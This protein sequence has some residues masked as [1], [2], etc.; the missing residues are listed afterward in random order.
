MLPCG[1]DGSVR[2][3][4][5]SRRA[6]AVLWLVTMVVVTVMAGSSAG[7]RAASGKVTIVHYGYYW[8]GEAWRGFVDWAVKEFEETH[9]N[10]DIQVVVAGGPGQGA[11]DQKFLSMLAGGSPPD[12]LEM[13]ANQ[14]Q[15]F[16]DENVLLD[17]RLLMDKEKEISWDLFSPITVKMVTWT[18]GRIWGLPMDA[19]PL[20][21]AFNQNLFE[22]AGLQT[23]VDLGPKGWTWDTMLA[24][25]R[26]LTVDANGDGVV[27]RYGL[28]G[29]L[30]AWWGA[31]VHQAGGDLYDRPVNPTRATYNRPEVIRGLKF[32]Q[33]LYWK[34][35]VAVPATTGTSPTHT[36]WLGNVGMST[37]EGPGLI[38][39]PF[40][41]D[42]KFAWDI[43]PQ[44]R[45]P[46][47]GGCRFTVDA[48]EI[49]SGTRHPTEAWEWVKFLS[50]NKAV[51]RR[52]VA[53]TA[54][55]T[56]FQPIQNEYS[57]LVPYAPL[58]AAYMVFELANPDSGPAYLIPA[59]REVNAITGPL[60]Q[61]ILD[62]K[63]DPSVVA[64]EI[65]E[66]LNRLLAGGK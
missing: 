24:A 36:I 2:Y 21:V 55:L 62:G 43:G 11:Y 63:R 3:G 41:R 56:A 46:V 44:P 9:P 19:Y 34:Y 25:A 30:W 12:V 57:K 60:I 14:A 39:Q 17:L 40:I 38:S 6:A 59:A 52:F 16:V 10:I 33:D 29:R 8:H 45:G 15:S 23:P 65:D 18:D 35:K 64:V 51:V 37:V 32:V 20:F 54:R 22:A 7:I 50:T 26:R 47:R 42:V 61:E 53:D 49:F 4:R 5:W 48:L 13:N 58:H 1:S 28:D 66:K 31:A 27:D